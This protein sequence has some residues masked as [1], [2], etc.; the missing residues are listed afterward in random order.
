[1]SNYL[2]DLS[3]G[4]KRPDGYVSAIWRASTTRLGD[5]HLSHQFD[6]RRGGIQLQ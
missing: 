1:M 3:F 6:C 5:F 4:V 2:L